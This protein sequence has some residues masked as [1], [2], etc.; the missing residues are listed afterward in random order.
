MLLLL[1]DD[2]ARQNLLASA[3]EDGSFGAYPHAWWELLQSTA[4][5][6][7]SSQQAQVQVVLQKLKD[8]PKECAAV[9]RAQRKRASTSMAARGQQ[10]RPH[11]RQ[12][13]CYRHAAIDSCVWQFACAKG[14]L[15]LA[16]AAR[17]LC[18]GMIAQLPALFVY[19]F[20]IK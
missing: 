13:Q 4:R 17:C 16:V 3:V 5:W 19:L 18:F 10:N 6:F 11:P 7:D 20:M 8:L 15:H 14:Y 9:A 1:E 12:V 2:K